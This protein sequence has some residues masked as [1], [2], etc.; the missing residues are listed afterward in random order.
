MTYKADDRPFPRTHSEPILIFSRVASIILHPLFMTAIA[1]IL[2]YKINPGDRDFR[3]WCVQIIL[4]TILFPFLSIFLLRVSGVISNV[5]MHRPSDRVVPLI[6]TLVFYFVA[7]EILISKYNVSPAMKGLLLGSCCAIVLI[8]L[9]NFFYKVSVH[10]SAAAIL[11]GVCIALTMDGT[12]T[13]I[14][15]FVVAVLLAVIVGVI[16]W[17]LG[18]HAMGQILLGYLVGIFSQ[19]ITHFIINS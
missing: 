17:F 4:F 1:A 13:N 19:V 11:L 2:L 18:A 6:V 3:I 5:T 14:L 10:T 9:I 15:L 7:Y 16:R 8:F 12:A